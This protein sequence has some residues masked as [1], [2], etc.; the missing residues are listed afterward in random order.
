M[1]LWLTPT[2]KTE[3]QSLT[4]DGETVADWYISD[5]E[6]SIKLPRMLTKNVKVHL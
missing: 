6:R 2:G 5:K 1:A 3:I 4:L